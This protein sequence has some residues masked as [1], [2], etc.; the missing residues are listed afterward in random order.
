MTASGCNPIISVDTKLITNPRHLALHWGTRDLGGGDRKIS[1]Q[2]EH[3]KVM[4]KERE[5][6]RL[7]LKMSVQT[8]IPIHPRKS[9][10]EDN[11][12]NHQLGDGLKDLVNWESALKNL[13]GKIKKE[14]RRSSWELWGWTE[15]G[16][17]VS[18]RIARRGDMDWQNSDTQ[19]QR[20]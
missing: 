11:Q 20:G 14:T 13:P 19:G 18:S 12:Q 15:R 3:V 17:N 1:R 5:K 10:A 4:S 9:D 16:C 7:P 2:G 6:N 8:P